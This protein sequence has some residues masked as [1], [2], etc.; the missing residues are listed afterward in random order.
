MDF[1]GFQWIFNGFRWISLDF[2]GFR[3]IL[4]NL[5]GP[6]VASTPHT[7]NRSGAESGSK[8]VVFIWWI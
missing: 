1:D 7:K 2:N 8:V 6:C 4:I 5:E 3:W